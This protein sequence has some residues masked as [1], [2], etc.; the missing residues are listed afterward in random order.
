MSSLT[1]F[2]FKPLPELPDPEFIDGNAVNGRQHPSQNVIV[3]AIGPCFLKC[4]YVIG[5]STTHT[6]DA[7]RVG[8]EQI[9]ADFGCAV[10]EALFTKNNIR[11]ERFD[12]LR[13]PGKLLLRPFE[14]ESAR[15]PCALLPIV[16]G[17]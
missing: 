9:P 12:A 13:E 10:V 11:F 16:E 3:P 2:F 4:E 7:S 15:R 6:I 17:G 8:E 14:K 5:F 1:C